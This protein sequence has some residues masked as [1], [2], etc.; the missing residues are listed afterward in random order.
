M[1]QL[2][3]LGPNP[4]S[5]PSRG[6]GPGASGWVVGSPVMVPPAPRAPAWSGQVGPGMQARGGM[7]SGKEQC[8]F[9]PR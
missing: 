2:R 3:R 6:V 7:N 9:P 4:S 1:A 5:L 8:P